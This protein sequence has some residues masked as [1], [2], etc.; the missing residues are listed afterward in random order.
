MIVGILLS[1]IFTYLTCQVVFLRKRV[2]T[3]TTTYN[4]LASMYADL[5]IDNT[6]LKKYIEKSHFEKTGEVATAMIRKK[7]DESLN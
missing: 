7:E 3:M 2:E 4:T 5:F 6:A 1:V